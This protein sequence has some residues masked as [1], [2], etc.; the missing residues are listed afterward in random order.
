MSIRSVGDGRPEYQVS[1]SILC[2]TFNL[3]LGTE[4]I[5]LGPIE[6]IVFITYGFQSDT[7]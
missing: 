7:T 2:V 1:S 3:L 6:Y 5:K 4:W